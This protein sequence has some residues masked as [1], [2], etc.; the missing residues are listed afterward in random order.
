LFFSV[1]TEIIYPRLSADGRT[2]GVAA[3]GFKYGASGTYAAAPDAIRRAVAL[4][5]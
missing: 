4:Y 3:H 1:R 5:V 2:A